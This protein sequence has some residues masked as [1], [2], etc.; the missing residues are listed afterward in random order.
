MV[1][2]INKKWLWDMKTMELSQSEISNVFKVSR[3][4]VSQAVHYKSKIKKKEDLARRMAN[5]GAGLGDIQKALRHRHR[6]STIRFLKNKNISL[7][8]P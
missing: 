4:A 7:R 2:R 6:D 8:K 5:N 1:N 3:Q